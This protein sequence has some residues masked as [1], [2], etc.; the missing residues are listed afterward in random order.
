MATTVFFEGTLQ[1]KEQKDTKID[2]EFGRSSFYGENLIYFAVDGKSVILDAKTGKT[3]YEKLRDL[4]IY[5][6][7]EKV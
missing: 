6:G 7:Y 4:A 2:L 5:L 3:I 1:D